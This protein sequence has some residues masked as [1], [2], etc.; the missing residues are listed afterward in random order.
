MESLLKFV[1]SIIMIIGV[2]T[3]VGCLFAS[4][5]TIGS[6]SNTLFVIS[7]SSLIGSMIYGPFMY[8][9][10][11]ISNTLKELKNENK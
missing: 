7:I 8:V 4:I 10:A 11:N 2:A 1:A 9:I 5:N 3:F 6:E